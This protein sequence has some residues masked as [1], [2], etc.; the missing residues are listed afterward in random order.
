MAGG[1]C[2]EGHA[3]ADRR[4]LNAEI[5]KILKMPEVRDKLASQIGMEI[6]ASTPAAADRADAKRDSALGELV[7]E[8]RRANAE[9]MA[10][11]TIMEL[12]PPTTTSSSLRH[13][14]IATLCTQLFKRGFRNV[15]LQGI[16]R[17]TKPSARQP[18]RA[19]VHDAQHPRARGPRPDQ[20]VRQSRASAAQGDRKRAARPCAGARLPRREARGL[21]R[22]RS[23]RRGSRCAAPRAWS[24]TGRCATAARSRRWISRC[25]APAAARRST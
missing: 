1:L 15:Y 25:T 18:G 17:L 9:L 2:A 12:D 11:G 7:E 19:R 13:V 24:P 3:E 8:V 6:V 20:R 4:R 23:S 14:S 10:R 22:R 16:A 21:G 5:V